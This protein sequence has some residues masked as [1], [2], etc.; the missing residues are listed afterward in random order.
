MPADDL[1]IFRNIQWNQYAWEAYRPWVQKM[2]LQDRLEI[3][4]NVEPILAPLEW[5][6]AGG[7]I[8]IGRLPRKN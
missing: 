2:R 3:S 4:E 8:W 1:K 7:N 5:H 6:N